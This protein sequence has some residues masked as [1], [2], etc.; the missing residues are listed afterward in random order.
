MAEEPDIII[1]DECLDKKPYVQIPLEERKK[2]LAVVKEIKKD[3]SKHTEIICRTPE[4]LRKHFAENPVSVINDRY[5]SVFLNFS[6]YATFSWNPYF[7]KSFFFL[8]K[9]GKK[10]SNVIT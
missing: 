3:K 5:T 10:A 1:L 7:F 4:T 6:W 9:I 8:L 2:R